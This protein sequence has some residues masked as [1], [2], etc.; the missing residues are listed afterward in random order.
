VTD[1][2]ILYLS[3]NERGLLRVVHDG[4]RNLRVFL[5]DAT[6]HGVQSA[7][8][9]RADEPLYYH[10]RTGPLGAALAGWSPAP[11]RGRVAVVGLGAGVVAAYAKPGMHFTFLEIDPRVA[12]VALDPKLFTYLA[13]CR[14][15]FDIVFGD[16]RAS[17]ERA[18][19]AAFDVL[20]LDA[21]V[22][23]V[24][25][26]HFYSA[27]A[28]ALYRRKLTPEGFAVLQVGADTMLD[29]LRQ[30]ARDADLRCIHRADLVVSAEER[31]SGKAASHSAVLA[32]GLDCVPWLTED[33]RWTVV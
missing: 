15:T 27:D 18:D 14:G 4:D 3:M 23:D 33:P 6:A 10:H 21:F 30:F 20:V 32:R 31:A 8:P 29:G 17:L 24:P 13:R 7:D 12:D 5:H 16:G 11:G 28:F 2:D 25:P 22:D 19:D 1:P 9:E 26:P